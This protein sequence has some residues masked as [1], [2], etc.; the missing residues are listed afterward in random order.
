MAN[1]VKL[2]AYSLFSLRDAQPLLLE[3]RMKARV[4]SLSAVGMLA[5]AASGCG[6]SSSSSNSTG[7]CNLASADVCIQFSTTGLS[8]IQIAE[9]TAACTEQGLTFAAQA[10]STTNVLTGS[11]AIPQ[12]K[13]ENF[14]P[15][16]PITSAQGFFYQPATEAEAQATCQ[17][18]V[19]SSGLGGTWN[20]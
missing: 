15:S 8:T 18:A 4:L 6:G 17:A 11:C 9:V 1:P 16:A 14:L 20:P 19:N 12:A 3:R 13:I 2:P 10:C 5:F 7:S